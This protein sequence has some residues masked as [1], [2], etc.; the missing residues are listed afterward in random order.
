MSDP[1]SFYRPEGKPQ[2]HGKYEI[3]IIQ[4]RTSIEMRNK[5]QIRMFK[6]LKHG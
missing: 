2:S 1:E 4:R 3:R 6:C 5:Y